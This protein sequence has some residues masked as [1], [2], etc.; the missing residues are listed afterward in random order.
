MLRGPEA[1]GVVA[2]GELPDVVRGELAPVRESLHVAPL[3]ERLEVARVGFRRMR[4]QP[5]LVQQVPAEGPQP[6]FGRGIH[7]VRRASAQQRIRDQVAHAAEEL[8]VHPRVEAVPV[9]AAEG[10]QSERRL[11][12]ERQ[13]RQ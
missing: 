13:Q 9:R 8:R 5:A 2:T 11:A 4:R 1:R 12:T 10:E 7:P 6:V 3:H